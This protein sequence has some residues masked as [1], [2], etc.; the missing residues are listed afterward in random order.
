M[1]DS[2]LSAFYLCYFNSPTSTNTNVPCDA[3]VTDVCGAAAHGGARAAGGGGRG[4]AER[5]HRHPAAHLRA[6]EAGDDAGAHRVALPRP[7]AARPPPR[8][9]QG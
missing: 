9:R 8:R 1:I 2:C 6:A 7:P 3:A 4:R 5:R